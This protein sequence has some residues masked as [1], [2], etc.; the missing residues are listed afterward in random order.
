MK[1]EAGT[2]LDLTFPVLFNLALCYHGNRDVKNAGTAYQRLI[3]ICEPPQVPRIRVMIGNLFY[4]EKKYAQAIK[5]YK[6]AV[7]QV[8]FWVCKCNISISLSGGGP[9]ERMQGFALLSVSHSLAG[10]CTAIW[11]REGC[12]S[13]LSSSLLIQRCKLPL[14]TSSLSPSRSR[15]CPTSPSSDS[16]PTQSFTLNLLLPPPFLPQIPN[17]SKDLKYKVMRNIAVAHMRTGQYMEA[18]EHLKQIMEA[19]PDYQA[20]MNYVLCCYIRCGG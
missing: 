10:F 14:F 18:M 9:W 19:T 6:M 17:S 16:S 12:A 11:K 3:K 8:R 13:A 15:F 2:Q 5:H 1:A 20:G 7:D 4:E